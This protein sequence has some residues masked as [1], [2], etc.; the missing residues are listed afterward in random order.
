MGLDQYLTAKRSVFNADDEIAKAFD[1]VQD[2]M[3]GELRYIEVRA[4]YWRKTNHIH[5]W[6]VEKCQGGK[7]ECQESHVSKEQLQDLLDTVK[8]VLADRTL[9]PQLLP[10]RPGFFFG[11][12]SYEEWYFEDLEA[13]KTALEK[14]MQ[15]TDDWD[16][17]YRASW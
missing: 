4:M 9:A 17:Y 8:K 11:D 2:K 1:S 3:P 14:I 5:A 13:T 6:F 7:D 16:F 15:Y 10:T 12:T